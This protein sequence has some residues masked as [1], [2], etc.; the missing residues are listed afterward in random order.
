MCEALYCLITHLLCFVC[1]A[2]LLP[3]LRLLRQGRQLPTRALYLLLPLPWVQLPRG[4][5]PRRERR[6]RGDLWQT[7][8]EAEVTEV[9]RNTHEVRRE[10]GVD[11]SINNGL[12]SLFGGSYG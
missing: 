2:S 10:G 6:R 5:L 3:S 7:V 9:L 8:L 11:G 1:L 12:L 4:D